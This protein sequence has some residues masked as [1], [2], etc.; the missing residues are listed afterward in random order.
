MLFDKELK[1]IEGCLFRY[2]KADEKNIEALEEGKLFFST[3][4]YFNDPYDGLMYVDEEKICTEF[5]NHWDIGMDGYLK[6][7]KKQNLLLGTFFEAAWGKNGEKYRQDYF[8]KVGDIVSKIKESIKKNVKVV[9]LSERADLIL[10]WSHYADNHRG[11]IM[12]YDREEL[13]KAERFDKNGVTLS[14]KIRVDRV[15]YSEEIL[16]MSEEIINYIRK[17]KLPGDQTLAYIPDISQIKLRE[18]MLRKASVWQYENEYRI[19]PRTISLEKS[20]PIKYLNVYPKAIIIGGE[21]KN[22]DKEKL[23]SIARKKGIAVLHAE[24]LKNEYRIMIKSR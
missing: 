7:V 1:I 9:C 17:Y 23:I 2:R 22:T 11:F 14:D 10:M 19:L 4:Q 3:P 21:C 15:K 12:A 6:E 24:L 20:C 8:N 13:L 16:E 5:S 18:F